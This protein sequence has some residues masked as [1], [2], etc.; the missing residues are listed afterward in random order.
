[1]EPAVPDVP[2]LVKQHDVVKLVA[3]VGPLRVVQFG[4]AMQDGRAGQLIR[5]RNVDSQHVVT[6]R[7]VDRS[8]V[9]VDY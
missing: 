4:E 8:V 5:V 6:G 9:E 7:V 3:H 1:V 2:I